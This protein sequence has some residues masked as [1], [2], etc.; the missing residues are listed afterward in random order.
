MNYNIFEANLL[1]KAT[2]ASYAYKERS[3]I[4][5]GMTN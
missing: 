5:C 2:T 4:L 1:V 3:Y